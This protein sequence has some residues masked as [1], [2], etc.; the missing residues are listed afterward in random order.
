MDEIRAEY[1]PPA[2]VGAER[3]GEVAWYYN[4]DRLGMG[5]TVVGVI[6]DRSG[7]VRFSFNH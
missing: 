3:D 2:Q 6:F 4:T 5:F 7:R 1:G